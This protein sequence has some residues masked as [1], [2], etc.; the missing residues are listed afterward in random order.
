[1]DRAHAEKVRV[2]P[3]TLNQREDVKA[4]ADAGVDAVITDDPLMAMKTLDTAHPSLRFKVL[5]TKLAAVRRTGQAARAREL[6]EPAT[7]VRR[8]AHRKG[9]R[10]EG[11]PVPGRPDRARWSS[12]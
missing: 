5:A 7:H 1:M 4:A 6:E 2:V 9:A 11:A 12:S 10:L 8:A 3:Y